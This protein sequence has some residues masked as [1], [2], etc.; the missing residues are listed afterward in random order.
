MS[1]RCCGAGIIYVPVGSKSAQSRVGRV[2]S[3]VVMTERNVLVVQFVLRAIIMW[4]DCH[5]RSACLRQLAFETLGKSRFLQQRAH[6]KALIH[7][8]VLLCRR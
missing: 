4:Y 7:V 3:E 5:L 1:G 8:L 2:Y 6:Q